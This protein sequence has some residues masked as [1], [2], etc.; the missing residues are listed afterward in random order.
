MR[1]QVPTVA[2]MTAWL[3]KVF[4]VLSGAILVATNQNDN[5]DVEQLFQDYFKWKLGKQCFDY[6]GLP[7]ICIVLMLQKIKL[8]IYI[9]PNF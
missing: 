8:I 9:F 2:T 4:F 6:I 5:A 7:S 1:F 3:K